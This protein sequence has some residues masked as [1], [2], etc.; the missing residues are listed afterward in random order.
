M[1]L[2][3]LAS[4]ALITLASAAPPPGSLAARAS[5]SAS[6]VY[7]DSSAS[8]FLLDFV[9]RASGSWVDDWGQG[10]LDNLRGQCGTITNWGFDFPDGTGRATF[11]ASSL[12][13]AGCVEDAIWLASNP[14]GAINGDSF[15]DNSYREENSEN[16]SDSEHSFHSLHGLN[17]STQTGMPRWLQ[18]LRDRIKAKSWDGKLRKTSPPADVS[19][20]GMSAAQ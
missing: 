4:A 1:R 6:C 11:S 13:K 8:M 17:T 18:L 16:M 5:N 12:L 3:T 7:T 10:F 15:T 14:T 20:S 19:I 9:V 2:L